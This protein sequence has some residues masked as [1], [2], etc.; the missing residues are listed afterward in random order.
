LRS[1]RTGGFFNSLAV[2][3]LIKPQFKVY[4]IGN[5][6]LE[7]LGGQGDAGQHQKCSLVEAKRA[8]TLLGWKGTINVV[9]LGTPKG[10]TRIT[11]FSFPF[12]G[13][14]GEWTENFGGQR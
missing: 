11:F 10:V 12:K 5:A 14:S 6:Q 9:S 2:V 8:G 1:K 4:T 13:I 7:G 3:V